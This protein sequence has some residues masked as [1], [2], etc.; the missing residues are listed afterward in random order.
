MN[1]EFL[2]LGAILDDANDDSLNFIFQLFVGAINE[3]TIRPFGEAADQYIF[4]TSAKA[5][6]NQPL[7]KASGHRPT[8]LF[9]ESR[10]V[11]H[12]IFNRFFKFDRRSRPIGGARL[13]SHG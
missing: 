5:I 6:F 8:Q 2:A 10:P 1:G 11:D 9:F 4:E 3:S 12:K 7:K 13:A